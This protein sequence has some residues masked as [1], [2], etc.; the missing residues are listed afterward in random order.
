MEA[1]VVAADAELNQDEVQALTA[2]AA[3]YAKRHE[4]MISERADD[5]SASAVAE[6]ERYLTLHSALAKLGVRLRLP[7]GISKPL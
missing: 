3:W 6:R 4:S 5:P 1:S 7:D 2:A